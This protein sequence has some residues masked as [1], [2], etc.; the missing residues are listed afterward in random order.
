MTTR[1]ADKALGAMVWNGLG[2][3]GTR[4]I[5]FVVTVVLARLLSPAEFGMVAVLTIFTAIAATLVESGFGTA[6]IQKQTVTREEESAVFHFNLTMAAVLYVAFWFL[7]SPIARF[8]DQPEL[9]PLARVLALVFLFN[10]FGLVQGCLLTKQLN[11]RVQTRA[12]MLATVLSGVL[13]IA[14][15]I[16][17]CGVWSL[18]AQALGNAFFRSFLLWLQSPWRPLWR[19]RFDALRG[20]FPYGS[21]LLLS[22]L[23]GVLFENAYV[24]VIGKFFTKADVGFYTRAQLTQ[25]LATDSLTGVVVNVTFPVYAS[26]QDDPAELREGYRRSILYASVILFPLMFGLAAMAEPLF[27]LLF[28]QKWAPSIPYFRILCL[29]GALYHLQALNLSVLKAVGRSDLYLRLTVVKVALVLTAMA[30][31]YRFGMFGLVWGQAVVAW[32]ALGINSLYAGRL[33]RFPLREQLRDVLP[34]AGIGACAAGLT[35]WISLSLGVLPLWAQVG[36]LA[37]SQL[38]LYGAIAWLFRVKAPFD[39]LRRLANHGRQRIRTR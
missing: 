1:L 18:V 27:L 30:I 37:L 10:A 35:H 8:Y 14:M 7:A 21:R 16:L 24:I 28:T 39:L 29:A 22:S 9:V 2:T 4:A 6:L 36:V 12:L 25:R 23:L 26:V 17:G 3:F 33:I 38:F 19:M 11:F 13:G 20:M 32:L 34:Y 31:T 15:A 5:Q